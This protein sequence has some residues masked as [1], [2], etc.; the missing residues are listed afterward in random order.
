MLPI[1]AQESASVTRQIKAS[2]QP[3]DAVAF[4]PDGQSLA[5]TG[6]DQTISLWDGELGE[7]SWQSRSHEDWVT[8]LAFSPDG[9]WLYTG[10][11]DTT[12]R[13]VNAQTGKLDSILGQHDA[14]ITSLDAS[15]DGQWVAS[16]DRNGIV[17]LYE[18]A[19]GQR[20]AHLEHDNGPNWQALFSDDGRFLAVANEDGPVSLYTVGE[21]A[22]SHSFT[23]YDGPVTRIAFSEDDQQIVT[24]SLSGEISVWNISSTTP[25]ATSAGHRAPIMGLSWLDSEHLVSTSLDGTLIIWRWDGSN[26]QPIYRYENGSPLLGHAS[27]GN[28]IALA[29]HQGVLSLLD[30]PQ[31]LISLTPNDMLVEHSTVASPTE[32]APTL[33]AP[34]VTIPSVGI[35]SELTTFPLDG[36]GRTW[37]IDPWEHRVGHFYG[38]S[39]L[40]TV[41]NIVLGAHSEYPDGTP[42][43]FH[44]LTDV[45][46]GDAIIVRD[47]DLSER[48]I[49]THIH[50]VDYRDVSVVYPTDDQRLTLITC[51]IPSYVADQGL[52]YERLV[53]VA[54]KIN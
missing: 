50:S 39:W 41:G 51:D 15:L 24:G 42:G 22:L 25:I 30:V 40:G 37:D 47:G 28:I 35:A 13:R 36:V 6:R 23:A 29:D 10:S 38:T 34:S 8:A 32:P 18:T 12:V 52:Y 21:W 14:A 53:V 27:T 2:D 5:T 11:R 46:L 49:V 3:I 17:N 20:V 16:S 19:S 44:A 4:A 9:I 26:L 31:Q 7:Q 33:P 48:Y 54:Q 1:T 45:G 43:T